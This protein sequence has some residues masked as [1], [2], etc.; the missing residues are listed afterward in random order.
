V[1]LEAGSCKGRKQVTVKFYSSHGAEVKEGE[2]F[3]CQRQVTVN[4]PSSFDL[5]H[6]PTFG[7]EENNARLAAV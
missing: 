4:V 6:T 3:D 7:V 5:G 1:Q 2:N